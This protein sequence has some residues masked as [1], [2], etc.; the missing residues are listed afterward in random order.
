MALTQDQIPTLQ[1]RF[2]LSYHLPYLLQGEAMVGL[3]QMSVLEVGG[4]L[5]RE[6][7]IDIL[8]ACRT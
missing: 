4:S 7:V 1:Q 5:P 8:A 6:L 3:Q 2:G